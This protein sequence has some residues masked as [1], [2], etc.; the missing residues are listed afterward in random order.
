MKVSGLSK[1]VVNERGALIKSIIEMHS[2]NKESY[3]L[4]AK[5]VNVGVA[6]LV[7]G[8]DEGVARTVCDVQTQWTGSG[9]GY[10]GNKGAVGARFR[11]PAADGGVGEIFTY[12][13]ITSSRAG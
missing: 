11:V 4:I 9:P 5:I 10:M 13:P 6:L 1:P 12:A 8:R 7:Y 3:T 2:P